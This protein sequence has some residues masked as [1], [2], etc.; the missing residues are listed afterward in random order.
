MKSKEDYVGFY[1]TRSEYEYLDK[2]LI[3][4]SYKLTEIQS[5]FLS[6]TDQEF[7][8]HYVDFEKLIKCKQIYLYGLGHL[9]GDITLATLAANGGSSTG[10]YSIK[11]IK[12]NK[13]EVDNINEEPANNPYG[14]KTWEGNYWSA[15]TP[16]TRMRCKYNEHIA[17]KDIL[18]K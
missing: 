15:N 12:Q 8:S 18:R 10:I 6:L 17:F 5:K 7:N 13:T 2:K 1:L 14:T 9:Y 16:I 4:H 11:K 3:E